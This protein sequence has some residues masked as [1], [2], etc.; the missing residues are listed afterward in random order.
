MKEKLHQTIMRGVFIW[1]CVLIF[2]FPFYWLL[3]TSFKNRADAFAMP[4]KWLFTPILDNFIKVFASG[5]FVSSYYNSLI[6][7]IA[8]TAISLIVGM[9]MAYG[10]SNR[11]TVKN[12]Q[13]ILLWIL[14]TKMAPPMMVAIPFY[15][16]FMTLHLRD[17]YVGMILIYLIFNL[18]FTVW[19]LHGFIDG[20]P[21]ELEEAARVDGA[22]RINAL[23]I[24]IVPMIKGG[25]AATGII[26]FITSW[27][28][29]LM[30]LLLTSSSTKTV[31]VTITNFIT[32]T[33]GIRWGEIAA[34][35]VLVTIPVIV[36][37]IC[38]RRYLIAGMTMG[39]V[40]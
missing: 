3:T 26:C 2:V 8:S 7:A 25:I 9:P 19:M 11:F 13:G 27:N 34:A 15:I 40:K 21:K 30:A 32:L 5:T 10:L 14:S 6:I 29:F 31:S 35:S 4:P 28:E 1:I 33:E 22:T 23:F 39:A 18:S 20:I 16:I 38:V 12:R 24:M 17:S 37:G 36:M